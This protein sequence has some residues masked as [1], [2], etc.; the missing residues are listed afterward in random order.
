[1]S[2]LLIKQLTQNALLGTNRLET[3]ERTKPNFMP[4]GVR[5]VISRIDQSDPAH[6]L[7]ATAGVVAM[8]S[9][10][11]R[12]RIDD[13]L[14]FEQNLAP[15]PTK[16]ACPTEFEIL[17]EQ[18]RRRGD[19]TLLRQMLE[20]VQAK[21]WRLPSHSI[22]D[23]LKLGS[24]NNLMRPYII[25]VLDDFDRWMAAQK[26]EWHYALLPDLAWDEL[27]EMWLSSPQQ[28]R[29]SIMSWLRR[30]DPA[31]GLALLE[32]RWADEPDANRHALLNTLRHGLSMVAEPFIEQALDARQM[33]VRKRAHEL[34]SMLSG[35]R[36]CKRME[37]FA[38]VV[39]TWHPERGPYVT[40]RL[41]TGM[42]AAMQRA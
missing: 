18:V 27:N 26:S 10:I 38:A 6:E 35:S 5:Q 8:H 29:I 37:S 17:F 36:F 40:I 22:P 3:Q 14:L 1:M 12:T 30:T 19:I 41:P 24:K 31:K 33:I 13:S 20:A 28:I 7:L 11:G 39:F 23:L 34:L 21:G 16:P 15:E 9:D 2:Q 4:N 42:S 32:A 25:D